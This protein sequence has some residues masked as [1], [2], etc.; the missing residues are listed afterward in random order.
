MHIEPCHIQNSNTFRTRGIFKSLLN[1]SDDHVYSKPCM[2]NLMQAFSR[3]VRHIQGYWCIFIHTNRCIAREEWEGLHWP[4][5]KRN[6]LI[7]KKAWIASIF[8]LNFPFKILCNCVVFYLH[9]WQD[10]YQH[11]L[12][13]RDLP[14]TGNFW[15]CAC[16]QALF[17]LQKAPS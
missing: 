14:C 11:A 10:F 16:T 2:I 5:L 9:F 1:I 7:G 13:P 4:F 3:M 15:L 6:G 17:F 8:G 12:F